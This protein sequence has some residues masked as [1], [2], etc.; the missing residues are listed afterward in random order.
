MEGCILRLEVYQR[1]K[2]QQQQ[3]WMR[4]RQ[5]LRQQTEMCRMSQ[6]QGVLMGMVD[7]D[8]NDDDD[9]DEDEDNGDTDADADEAVEEEMEEMIE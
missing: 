5:R 9:I 4:L 7:D 3:R 1:V 8:D 2:S 6:V